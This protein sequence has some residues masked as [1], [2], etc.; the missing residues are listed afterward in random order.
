MNYS[1]RDVCNLYNVH[2]QTVLAW[3]HNGELT[4]VNVGS[5]P[6]NAKPRWRITQKALDAFEAMRSST[7]PA[8]K[9]RRRAKSKAEVIQ[10]YS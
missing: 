4:A 8:P 9:T 6:A 7:P 3:I 2:E 1:I 10:F 5:H